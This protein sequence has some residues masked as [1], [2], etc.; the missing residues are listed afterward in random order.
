MRKLLTII[1]LIT[2]IIIGSVFSVFAQGEVKVLVRQIGTSTYSYKVINNSEKEIKSLQIGFN[3]HRKDSEEELTVVPTTIES[4]QGWEGKTIFLEESDYLHIYWH[5]LTDEYFIRPGESLD[6]FIVYMSQSYELMKQTYFTVIFRISTGV[7]YWFSAKVQLDTSTPIL[8]D[9]KGQR[10]FDVNTFL[11]YLRPTE[12][13][14]TLPQGQTTYYLLIFYG[15][16]ILP[17]T[18]KANLNGTD[19]KGSFNPKP[20]TSE[21]VKLNLQKVRNTLVLSV[22]GIRDD[23][24]RATDTDRLVFLVW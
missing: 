23:G 13:Q 10:P 9:G 7:D 16:T 1:L 22:D 17:E 21:A 14:T 19:I 24:K 6:G 12:A 8:F 2:L 5:R 15:K 4:P 3:R 20:D 18:F 11:A